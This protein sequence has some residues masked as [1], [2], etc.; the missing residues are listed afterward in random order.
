MSL[1]NPT[2]ALLYAQTGL[3]AKFANEAVASLAAQPEIAKRMAAELTNQERMQ[4]QEMQK[5]DPT[6]RMI[7]DGGERRGGR[8]FGSRRRRRAPPPVPEEENTSPP[9]GALVGNLLNL[10]I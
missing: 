10:K 9:A 4:V 1:V 8:Q 6:G 7:G 3:A 2:V 5:G